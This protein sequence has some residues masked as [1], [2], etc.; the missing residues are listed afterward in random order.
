MYT[1][2]LELGTINV[3]NLSKLDSKSQQA[4]MFHRHMEHHQVLLEKFQRLYPKHKKLPQDSYQ[5]ILYLL[6]DELY[7]V[8]E[9]QEY[10]L[11]NLTF[12]YAL[13]GTK[14]DQRDEVVLK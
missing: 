8:K 1:K 5:Y 4:L 7:A 14:I 2:H 9:L 10:I 13:C 12:L 11:T 3:E 6:H